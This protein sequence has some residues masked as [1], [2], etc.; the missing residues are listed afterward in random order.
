LE[1]LAFPFTD[2]FS[3][4]LAFPITDF[5]S[6]RAILVGMVVVLIVSGGI[7]LGCVCREV[8]VGW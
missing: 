3:E 5:F 7:E 6:A 1:A 8:V 2:F 4:A